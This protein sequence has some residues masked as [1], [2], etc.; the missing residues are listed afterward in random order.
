MANWF[1]GKDRQGKPG[2]DIGR[3]TVMVLL[4]VLAAWIMG[5]VFVV[6]EGQQAV[7]TR[8]GRFHSIRGAGVHWGLPFPIDQHALLPFAESGTITIGEVPP[9]V[10]S[11]LGNATMLTADG[12]AVDVRLQVQY[13]LRDPRAYFETQG[14]D[15]EQLIRL[16]GAASMREVVGGMPLAAL[17][18]P[19][20]TL[21]AEQ[22]QQRLQG[23]LEAAKTGIDVSTIK[24]GKDAVRAP[25]PLLPAF[26]EAA[27]VRQQHQQAMQQVQQQGTQLEAQVQQEA[28]ALRAQAQ[29]YKA[30][31]VTEAQEES[32]RFAALLP[33]YKEAPQATRDRLYNDTMQQVFSQTRKVVVDG[34]AG[35]TIQLPPLQAASGTQVPASGAQQAAS[36]S[37]AAK[38]VASAASA[39]SAAAG[40]KGTV[41]DARSRDPDALR[42]RN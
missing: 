41:R 39:A 20:G 9:P 2:H 19:D 18:Q 10:G 8:L 40:D 24:M 12:R 21:L 28:T 31:T 15:V 14:A 11:G 30:A 17:M 3:T 27:T 22:V 13:R 25:D 4:A 37:E 16:A 34:R 29:A 23:R 26:N 6:K 38:P 36:G 42:S 7:V 33:A 35:Y 1:G 5:G 32:A